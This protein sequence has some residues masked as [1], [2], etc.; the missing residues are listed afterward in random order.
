M[1]KESF[2]PLASALTFATLIAL[3]SIEAISTSS[4]I[5]ESSS[6]SLEIFNTLLISSIASSD[7]LRARISFSST[8]S[9]KGPRNF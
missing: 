2:T 3:A 4:L 9:S 7:L 6:L 5:N 8:T 1:I